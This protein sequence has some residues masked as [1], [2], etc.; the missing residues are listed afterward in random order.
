[1]Y[2]EFVNS[3]KCLEK[4][5]NDAQ[6][7]EYSWYL[8]LIYKPEDKLIAKT[9]TTLEQDT[10]LYFDFSFNKLVKITRSYNN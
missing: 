8:F 2:F 4:Q 1:M 10:K 6:R 3:R 5:K 9:L 7:I